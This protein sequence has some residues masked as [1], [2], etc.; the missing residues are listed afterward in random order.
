MPA[1]GVEQS[2]GGLCRTAFECDDRISE[3]PQWPYLIISQHRALKHCSPDETSI[4]EKS[5]QSKQ[6]PDFTIKFP[7]SEC[8]CKSTKKSSM[9]P[10]QDV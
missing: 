5:S 2:G 10:L 4:L 8:F 3:A 6:A 1:Y 9:T 7:L